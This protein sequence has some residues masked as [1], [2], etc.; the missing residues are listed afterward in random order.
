MTGRIK[1]K[2]F[3]VI[4]VIMIIFLCVFLLYISRLLFVRTRCVAFRDVCGTRLSG[5]GMAMVI[6]S[7]DYDDEYPRAGGPASVWARNVKDWKAD[8]RF[9]AYD[10]EMDGSGGQGNISA[11]LYLLV[12]YV[13]VEPKKF[14]CTEDKKASEFIPHRYRVKDEDL[15]LLWDFGPNPQKHIS[16]SYQMVYSPYK[17][18]ASSDPDMAILAD[19]N[20][21]IDSPFQKAKDFSKFKPE[22]APFN[23]TREQMRN[24]NC[25]S[26][27]DE[28]QNVLFRDGRVWF[29]DKPYCGVDNDNIYTYWD[30]DDR[31]RG[32]PAKFGSEPASELDSLLVNDPPIAPNR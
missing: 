29:D 24:G 12:K 21:W 27:K 19:R 6:Y 23:G 20:P 30:G 32:R 1:N 16:Y 3:T 17:L 5:I 28:G 9:D 8:N 2:A 18:T 31:V 4:E 15:C 13:E 7:C 14:I 22:I 25:F 10:I 11:S 26:H